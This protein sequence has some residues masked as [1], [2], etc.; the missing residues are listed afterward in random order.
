MSRKHEPDA[1]ERLKE[2]QDHAYNPGYW[3][4]RFP[5]GFPPKPSRGFWILALID[6]FVCVPM[7]VALLLRYLSQPDS[8]LLIPVIFTGGMA[9]LATLRLPRLR[10][11]DTSPRDEANETGEG[12]STAKEGGPSEPRARRKKKGLPKRRKDY[13]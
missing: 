4:N 7:F 1:I 3:V 6:V 11:R 5:L 13:R 9:V 2:W 12:N 10:P 8:L